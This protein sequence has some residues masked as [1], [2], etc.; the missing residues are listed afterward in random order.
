MDCCCLMRNAMKILMAPVYG[1]LR[2][3]R[4]GV[5]REREFTPSTDVR[6]R[7]DC[8]R[9][10]HHAV[11]RLRQSAKTR[12][13]AGASICSR[14]LMARGVLNGERAGYSVRARFSSSPSPDVIVDYCCLRRVDVRAEENAACAVMVSHVVAMFIRVI[15]HDA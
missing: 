1:A 8:R 7:F 11:H 5:W 13:C 2:H 14:R 15:I 9:L 3:T 6:C 4:D 10:R 12:S